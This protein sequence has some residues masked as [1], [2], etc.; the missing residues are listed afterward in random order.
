[1]FEETW[2]NWVSKLNSRLSFFKRIPAVEKCLDK[3]LIYSIPYQYSYVLSEYFQPPMFPLLIIIS[4]RALRQCAYASSDCVQKKLHYT[5]IFLEIWILGNIV[6]FFKR[7][8]CL[9][10]KVF[11]IRLEDLL[12]TS[13]KTSWRNFRKR[14]IKMMK[15]SWRRLQYMPLR[16]HKDQQ[17]IHWEGIYIGI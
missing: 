17:N 7:T 15:T 14:K 2:R 11:S 13:C 5:V 4:L 3:S 10:S 9:S 1:M 12:N 8:C 6:I 16:W